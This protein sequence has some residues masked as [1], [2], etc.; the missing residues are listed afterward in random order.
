[1]K[2]LHVL[3]ITRIN[4]FLILLFLSADFALA[5]NNLLPADNISKAV[6]FTEKKHINNSHSDPVV[7]S[8]I[9]TCNV[10]I[11]V[12]FTILKTK[13]NGCVNPVKILNK[14]A[15][16]SSIIPNENR[17]S[18]ILDIGGVTWTNSGNINITRTLLD[19]DLSYIKAGIK[20]DSAKLYLYGNPSTTIGSNVAPNVL[21]IHRITSNWEQNVVTWATQPNIDLSTKVSINSS[22][23]NDFT[24]IVA[25]VSTMLQQYLDNRSNSFGFMLKLA[26]E[27]P[28][29]RMIFAS[30]KSPDSALHP[31]LIVYYKE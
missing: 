2:S 27:T 20:I 5:K 26:N 24:S 11:C 7:N 30:S 22:S 28:Y 21:D 23:G 10:T 31:K 13:C 17:S 25:N 8:L 19:F 3:V 1:M 12:P 9:S 16:I 29:R 4:V 15:T 18:N 6:V 14:E